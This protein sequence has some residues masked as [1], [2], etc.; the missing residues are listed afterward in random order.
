MSTADR[1]FLED[2]SPA[3]A[4]KLSAKLWEDPEAQLA[5]QDLQDFELGYFVRSEGSKLQLQ[6]RYPFLTEV[7]RHGSQALLE[8]VWAG[9]PLKLSLQG[10]FLDI[11]LDTQALG[12]DVAA[13]QRCA[14]LLASTRIF[15]LIGP[16][17]E[18][19]RWLREATQGI[20]A[21]PTAA[22]DASKAMTPPP[23]LEFRVRQTETIWIVVK[24]DRVLIILSVHLDDEVDVALGRAFCQEFAETNRIPNNFS[25]PC[26]FHESKDLPNDL[27]NTPPAN[28]PNVGFLTLTLSDQSVRG[29]SEERL[30]TLAR[31][32]MTFR[33]F[34][35]FH[36][37]HAKSY[38]HSRLRR[39]LNG[40]EH[41]L[42]L[43]RRAPRL[44]Q[45]RRPAPAGGREPSAAAP[46]QA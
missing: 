11:A 1:L 26:S 34:F 36:L 44:P 18:R 39:R 22:K 38:L 45:K 3:L 15:L 40:W 43:A 6:V 25:P 27:R 4:A 7:L 32:V 20:A 30:H 9:L 2:C 33:N 42:N 5:E 8:R 37:K 35:L 17:V 13:R 16:L 21:A 10:E 23:P 14:R 41:V 24:Q 28:P 12:E 29:A 19:L 31:P 46:A